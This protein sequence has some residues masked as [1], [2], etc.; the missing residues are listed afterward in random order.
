MPRIPD[1]Y[2]DSSIYFYSGVQDA[3]DGANSGGCGFFV[4]IP[5]TQD[6]VIHIYAI[7]NKHILDE[8]GCV[9]RINTIDGKTEIIETT[10]EEWE[11]HP[12]GFDVSAHSI[13]LNNKPVKPFSVGIQNFLTKDIVKQFSLGTGDETFMVGRLITRYGQQKNKPVVRF[14]NIAMMSDPEEMIIGH[15]SVEQESFF[16]ECRSLSGASGSPVFVYSNQNY[17]TSEY[18]QDD[19]AI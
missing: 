19:S 3:K 16:V 7:T 18:L 4:H 2:L 9:L 14:G 13:D 11:D 6:G 10:R 15:N 17:T 1:V 8:V 5:S 12:E